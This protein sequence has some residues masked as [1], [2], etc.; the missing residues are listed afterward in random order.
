VRLVCRAVV[1]L[2]D[3]ARVPVLEEVYENLSAN[4][5]DPKEFYWTIRA[6]DGPRALRLR[7]IMRAEHGMENLRPGSGNVQPL[8]GVRGLPANSDGARPCELA[9]WLYP[10]VS[11]APHSL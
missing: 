8:S 9:A 5:L 1:A 6:L 7:R 3:D 2:D 11:F 4:G 10:S